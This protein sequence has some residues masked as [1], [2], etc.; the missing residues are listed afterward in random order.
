MI[1]DEGSTFKKKASGRILEKC[2]NTNVMLLN[3]CVGY[4]RNS[5]KWVLLTSW[6]F[7]K[8][9]KKE[10]KNSKNL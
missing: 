4:Y 5:K 6:P 1:K 2:R 10:R 8:H 9:L 3:V 7:F